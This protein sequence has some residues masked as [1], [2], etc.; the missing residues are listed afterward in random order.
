MP[1]RSIASRVSKKATM[2][3]NPWVWAPLARTT[4][5]LVSL[6]LPVAL[7]PLAAARAAPVALPVAPEVVVYSTGFDGIVG[8]EWSDKRTGTTPLE[9]QTYGNFL[10]QFSKTPTTGDECVTLTLS[11]LTPAT[12]HVTFDLLIIKS[13]DGVEQYHNA[14]ADRWSVGLD[15]HDPMLLTSFSTNLNPQTYPDPFNPVQYNP[16]NPVLAARYTGP[17]HAAD[18][19]A[20]EK[21]RLGFTFPGVGIQDA[22]YKMDFVFPLTDKGLVMKFSG[23]GLDGVAD[24]SWGLDN[25]VVARVPEPS[26]LVLAMSGALSLGGLARRVQRRKRGQVR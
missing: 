18:T 8:D 19:G 13:W 15:G 9:T 23:L 4:C 12:Y 2:F 22:V 6:V 7:L 21:N 3:R 10:G 25:V 17:S 11:D 14:E 16:S 20:F 5:A 26:A 1:C 24:A